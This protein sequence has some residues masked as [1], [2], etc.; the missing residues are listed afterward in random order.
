MCLSIAQ[1]TTLRREA[2][3]GG[4]LSVW[5]IAESLEHSSCSISV[6]G[7]GG[8][9]GWDSG[10]KPDLQTERGLA[11]VGTRHQPGHGARDGGA[12]CFPPETGAGGGTPAFPPC[13]WEDRRPGRSEPD[14]ESPQPSPTSQ[15]LV[16]PCLVI[17][18]KT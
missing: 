14:A 2:P 18:L 17:S 4:F 6:G 13:V 9:L 15:T 11:T 1:L 16:A 10:W 8:F 3:E 12:S 7:D 5:I